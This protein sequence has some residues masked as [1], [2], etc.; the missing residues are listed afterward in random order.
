[1]LK[2]SYVPLR[3]TS[4]RT[5]LIFD[6]IRDERQFTKPQFVGTKFNINSLR[7]LEHSV[8]RC[9]YKMYFGDVRDVGILHADQEDN[10][11]T[12]YKMTLQFREN[13]VYELSE[14]EFIDEHGAFY[15]GMNATSDELCSKSEEGGEEEEEKEEEEVSEEVKK[16]VNEFVVRTLKKEHVKSELNKD[17]KN[18]IFDC[19]DDEMVSYGYVCSKWRFPGHLWVEVPPQD[20]LVEFGCSNRPF[21]T[22]QYFCLS[23]SA[24]IM[25]ENDDIDDC[26][27]QC[28]KLLHHVGWKKAINSRIELFNDFMDYAY[29]KD[30]KHVLEI[31]RDNRRSLDIDNAFYVDA[32]LTSSKTFSENLNVRK[33]YYDQWEYIWSDHKTNPFLKGVDFDDGD[34]D[35]DDEDVVVEL[36][37]M[38]SSRISEIKDALNDL[39]EVGH[40]W[41]YAWAFAMNQMLVAVTTSAAMVD[42]L[43]RC[44]KED[45]FC[46]TINVTEYMSNSIWL[47]N[48]NFNRKNYLGQSAYATTIRTTEYINK[49]ENGENGAVY[50]NSAVNTMLDEKDQR[51]RR[52]SFSYLK[53][54]VCASEMMVNPLLW[55]EQCAR[56]WDVKFSD[57]IERSSLDKG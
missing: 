1:M 56:I 37:R 15:E 28:S 39:S 30:E 45:N 40:G 17:L 22:D 16:V 20:V 25:S 13:S 4:R 7:S 49:L 26:E 53:R 11:P 10:T 27:W 8:R 44:R 34:D 3:K 33:E 42:T 21:V 43:M 50:L 14:F 9:E 12:V 36:P 24:D 5:G 38:S 54:L 32:C 48:T 47:S 18:V 35:D 6:L 29:G 57:I 55:D 52:M 2:Y 46:Q 51:K 19:V 41:G 23:S 31:V